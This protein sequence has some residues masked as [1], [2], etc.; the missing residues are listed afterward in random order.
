MG[1]SASGT[2]LWMVV[3]LQEGGSDMQSNVQPVA[4]FTDS[5]SGLKAAGEEQVGI[6]VSELLR[7]MGAQ[8]NI[9]P[10]FSF[11]IQFSTCIVALLLQPP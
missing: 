10:S 7:L 11:W 5:L 9:S 1:D 3:V 4:S 6:H 8:G 2:D